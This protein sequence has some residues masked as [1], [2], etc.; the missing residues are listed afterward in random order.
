MIYLQENGQLYYTTTRVIQSKNELRVW[1]SPDYVQLLAPT[2]QLSLLQPAGHIDQGMKQFT[3]ATVVDFVKQLF[4]T[5]M[6][7][8]FTRENTISDCSSLIFRNL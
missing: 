6:Q 5:G 4:M 2:H 8:T 3:E 7:V 1:Y